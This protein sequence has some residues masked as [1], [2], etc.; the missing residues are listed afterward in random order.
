MYL[1]ETHMHTH[2]V[3]ACATAS[4]EEQVRYY[5]EK[6]FA[7]I[8]MTDHFFN[9]NSGCPRKLPWETKVRFFA[10]GYERAK[11]EGEKCDLD[12]FFGL[13]YTINGSDFLVYGLSVQYLLD[14]P[15]F[16]QLSAEQLSKVVR[17]E[18]GYIA[19]AHPFRKAF[20]IPSPQPISHNLLDGIE[21]NNASM[22]YEVNRKAYQFADK[23]KL[24][25]QAGSDS[26]DT[27]LKKPNGIALKN[28]ARD[29]FDI[30]NAIKSGQVTLVT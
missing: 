11:A 2:P 9:G 7:G 19:Q 16:D 10:D 4:P 27:Y 6:D 21:V 28:R 13:E 5:K 25:K 3:S 20:W 22:P 17:K 24:P 1:Y 8:I 14:N 26:H 12:V 15:D 30:I 23:H 18:G 29:I